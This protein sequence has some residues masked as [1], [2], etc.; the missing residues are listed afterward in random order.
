MKKETKDYVHFLSKTKQTEALINL[1]GKS[2]GGISSLES[3]LKEYKKLR[4]AIKVEQV[5]ALE[6]LYYLPK[7][8]RLA[9]LHLRKKEAKEKKQAEE[10]AK[11]EKRKEDEAKAKKDKKKVKKEKPKKKSKKPRSKKKKK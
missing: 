8:E 6:E 7:G 2:G 11:E 9:V 5:D 10:K 3:L 4:G 1:K